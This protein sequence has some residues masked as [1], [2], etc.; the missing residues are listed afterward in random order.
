[1]NLLVHC[2]G[3]LECMVRLIVE[4]VIV[5][6]DRSKVRCGLAPESD[7]IFFIATK[8][9]ASLQHGL[10]REKLVKKLFFDLPSKSIFILGHSF[11]AVTVNVSKT[12]SVLIRMPVS[13]VIVA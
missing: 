5:P 13:L 6:K 12:L 2:L 3:Y 7:L 11:T 4:F 1:M 9:E 8:L 10:M